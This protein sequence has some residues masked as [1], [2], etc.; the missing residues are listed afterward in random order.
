MN[1]ILALKRAYPG[2]D[3]SVLVAGAPQLLAAEPACI[4]GDAVKVRG[5][6]VPLLLLLFLRMTH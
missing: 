1:A 2:A 3:A 5:R 4:E 6:D